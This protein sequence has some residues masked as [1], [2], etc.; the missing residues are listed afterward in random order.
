MNLLRNW[1]L[2]DL[3][4]YLND[5]ELKE[6]ADNNQKNLQFSKKREQA[7]AQRISQLENE[8]KQIKEQFSQLLKL[9][10]SKGVLDNY[11]VSKI[12]KIELPANQ[13]ST[14]TE[15]VPGEIIHSMLKGEKR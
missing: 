11:D 2:G 8:N 14:H 4:L 9:L 6:Q 1:F 13:T 7:Q 5:K 10:K 12:D 3:G 15:Y